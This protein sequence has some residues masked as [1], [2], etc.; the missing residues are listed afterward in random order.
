MGRGV[1]PLGPLTQIKKEQGVCPLIPSTAFSTEINMLQKRRF[2]AERS[3]VY[4]DKIIL[5]HDF[6]DG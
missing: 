2:D 3:A 4:E 1:R 5:V 6:R